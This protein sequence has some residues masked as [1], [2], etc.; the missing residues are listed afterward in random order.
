MASLAAYGTPEEVSIPPPIPPPAKLTR[1]VNRLS[2][3]SEV[4]LHGYSVVSVET[5]KAFDTNI[6]VNGKEV[7][8]PSGYIILVDPHHAS[9]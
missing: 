4:V 1:Q 9:V 6:V 8:C 2:W 3:Y 5:I 7:E